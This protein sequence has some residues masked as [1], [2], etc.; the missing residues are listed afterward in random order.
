MLLPLSASATSFI[1][2]LQ[3]KHPEQSFVLVVPRHFWGKLALMF[4]LQGPGFPPAASRLQDYY[5]R[6]TKKDPQDILFNSSSE[7][8]EQFQ[9]QTSS[10]P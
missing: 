5:T 4:S 10:L 2:G 3:V 9:L 1:Q 7:I 6:V 8:F